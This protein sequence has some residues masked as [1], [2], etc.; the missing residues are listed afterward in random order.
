VFE[1]RK[2]NRSDF[3]LEDAVRHQLGFGLS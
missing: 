2:K 3:L 1:S